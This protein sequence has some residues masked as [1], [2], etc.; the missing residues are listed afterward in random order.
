[1]SCFNFLGL[2]VPIPTLPLESIRIRSEPLL[3][4]R[5]LPDPSFFTRK[6]VP[7]VV[8]TAVL[9]V[10]SNDI[11]TEESPDSNFAIVSTVALYTCSGL[12]GEVVP[13]PI[14][15]LLCAITESAK[16]VAPSHLGIA[17][18]VP[19]PVIPPPDEGTTL[20]FPTTEESAAASA[21][22]ITS[23]ATLK[24]EPVQ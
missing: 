12:L 18:V 22:A 19:L 17:L 3:K 16:T 10:A 15:L 23:S 6:S 1:L 4:N 7:D 5:K 13:I 2:V 24:E 8:N 14:L 11:A 9:S 20:Q 21:V